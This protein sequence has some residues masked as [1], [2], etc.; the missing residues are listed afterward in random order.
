MIEL[1]S[2]WFVKD[3]KNYSDNIV[4]EKYAFLT[5]TVGIVLNLLICVGKILAGV[6]SG[7]ISVIADGVN[8]LSDAGSS[9]ITILGFKI[10]N[11]PI[12]K[13]HPFG[14]GRMEYIAAMVVSVIIVV[15]GG[16]LI[17][18]SVEK[19]IT[20]ESVSIS[21]LTIII[22]AVSV[23]VKLYMFAYNYVWG[24]KLNAAAMK[25]TAYDSISD[26][27][28]TSVVLICSVITYFYPQ[29]VL[30]SYAGCLVAIFIIF[31][32]GKSFIEILGDLLGK[33][34][35]KEFV[36]DIEKFVLQDTIVCGIHD[37]VVH[38][39]GP[40]RIMLSLHAE[41][42][43][44][45]D[46]MEV[47]DHIDN[48]EQG[49]SKQ[50]KCHATIHMDPVFRSD[51]K[52]EGLRKMVVSIAKE[53]NE[54]F[55]VHDFRMNSGSTHTNLIFD[56]VAPYECKLNEEQI[57]EE[58]EKKVKEIDGSYNTVIQIDRPYV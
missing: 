39:Y 46:I 5:G 38:D 50:F 4:R 48:I 37:L 33:V 24:K 18:S 28:S 35:E 16:E 34:P 17:I 42:P 52:V 19:I 15:V 20:P 26:A 23:G 21:L 45:M 54:H 10:A 8:N 3:R 13:K 27:V 9:V 51:D 22:L 11:K 25:A 43:A 49:L 58:I 55:T 30:D 29:V 53:I 44:E 14:H 1:L 31:T 47:H 40:G 56:V 6:L 2:R 12:D 57:K 7:A 36:D 41:V 32:G